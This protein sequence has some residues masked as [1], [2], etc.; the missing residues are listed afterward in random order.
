MGYTFVAFDGRDPASFAAGLA[1]ERVVADRLARDLTNGTV[2]PHWCWTA[3]DGDRRLGREDWGGPPGETGPGRR[4]PPGQAAPIVV[5][6]L[7]VVD[8]DAATALL[9]HARAELA[10]VDAW[11]ELNLPPDGG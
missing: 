9:V 6:Q 11:S 5:G 7:E 3:Y 1:E 2:R 4:G 8:V 10:V